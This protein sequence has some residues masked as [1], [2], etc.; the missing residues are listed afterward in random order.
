MQILWNQTEM[1]KRPWTVKTFFK[2]NNNNHDIKNYLKTIYMITIM[3][4]VLNTN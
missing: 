2:N 3:Y 4:E 1:K